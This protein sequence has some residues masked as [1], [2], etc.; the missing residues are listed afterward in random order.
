[1]KRFAVVIECPHKGDRRGVFGAYAPDVPDCYILADEAS[2]I[3]ELMRDALAYHFRS[4]RVSPEPI[5]DL[6]AAMQFHGDRMG[7][8]RCL[9]TWVDI[10]LDG[11]KNKPRRGQ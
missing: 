3:P 11:A 6:V 4:H 1:V 7:T 10:E 9:V 8:P 5:F 2:E